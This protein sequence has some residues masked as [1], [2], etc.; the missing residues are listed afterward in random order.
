MAENRHSQYKNLL[1]KSQ[2]SIL[3]IGC[4]NGLLG[5]FF[6]QL[7]VKYVGIDLDNRVIEQAKKHAI[8]VYCQDFFEFAPSH[9]STNFDVVVFS[10]VLEHIVSP[11]S[12]IDKVW[13]HLNSPGVLH[14]DVPNH[15]SLAGIIN[16]MLP[17]K[18]RFFGIQYPEHL[19]SY[20]TKT[21]KAL[22]DPKFDVCIFGASSLHD[23]YGQAGSY[24]AIE[25]AYFVVSRLLMCQNL[26]VAVGTK[27]QKEKRF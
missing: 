15:Y 3:E 17:S 27:K 9:S 1:N 12:F 25:K 5:H 11:V 8:E 26:L 20:K 19:F 10:Q 16:K 13:H 4:G 14:C 18:N 6:T 7:G 21:M 24:T 22:L 2:Y 23:T